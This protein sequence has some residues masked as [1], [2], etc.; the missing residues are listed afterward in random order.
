ME[1]MT[2]R[3]KDCSIVN[4]PD[5]DA[6]KMFIGQIPKTWNEKEVRELLEVYGP[7]YSINIL[8]EKPGSLLSKGCCFVTFYKRKAAL[9]AQN[10]L[11][12]VQ[13]LPGMHHCIQ[14]KPADLENKTE[15]RKL[16]VGMISKQMKKQDVLAMFSRFGSVE[17]CRV[18]VDR[19]G[20]SK[21]CAFVTFAKRASA[22]SA[23]Q[24]MNQSTTMEGCSAPIVVKIADSSKERQRK[25]S[26]LYFLS[27]LSQ[28]ANQMKNFSNFATLAP[29]LQMLSNNTTQQQQQQ[30]QPYNMNGMTTNGTTS[31]NL[32][33]QAMQSALML[34]IAAAAQSMFPPGSP[35]QQGTVGGPQQ[36][37]QSSAGLP[38]DFNTA[39]AAAGVCGVNRA[40]SSCSSSSLAARSP[41][42]SASSSGVSL[43]GEYKP[44]LGM[45]Q[46]HS[47]AGS[48]KEGPAGANL[49]IY[50]LPIH[51]TDYDLLE[52]FSPYGNVISAKVFIDKQTNI[53]KCFGFVS[54]DNPM[55]AY[56]AIQA[57]HGFQ[58]GTKRL[59]V[60][61][62]KVKVDN[63]FY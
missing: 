19:D 25:K 62:K 47:P 6:I 23:I 15:D 59:K 21:G 30:Q 4:Q 26:Q 24:H 53:S 42:L 33:P 40:T 52:S 44:P 29:I 2:D 28:L 36:T 5:A 63:K 60:Q 12:N 37:A 16:F 35:G 57:M 13:T 50:H 41:Y 8:R 1:S 9:D 22:L 18:L 51:F 10:A 34:A 56:H 61:L 32:S 49:F 3:F 48:Q 20:Y 54:Y 38:S 55:S 46:H 11:H 31:P 7:I 39:A 14:I 45:C 58:I 43:T 27:Q 17:E